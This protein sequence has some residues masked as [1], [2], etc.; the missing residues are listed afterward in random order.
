MRHFFKYVAV[1]VTLLW[2]LGALGPFAAT[3]NATL[4]DVTVSKVDALV[5][6]ELQRTGVESASIALVVDGRLAYAKAFGLARLEPVLAADP[7]QRYRIGSITKQFVAAAMVRLQTQGLLNLD[8][9]LER[10][11]PEAGAAGRASLRQLLS[12][13]AGVREYFPQ[14]YVFAELLV[15]TTVHQLVE[16]IA[17]HPLD[18]SPGQRWKYSNSG[19]VLAGAVV[20]KVTGKSLFQ[21]LREQFFEPMSMTSAVDA[22][23]VGLT[24]QDPIGYSVTGLGLPKPTQNMAAGWLSAAGGLGMSAEDLAKW[25]MALM[26]GKL[27]STQEHKILGTEMLLNNGVGSRYALGLNVRMVGGRRMWMHDG[28][29]PGFIANNI[30][31]PDDGLAIVV[32]TNGDF[33]DVAGSI[34]GRLHRIPVRERGD[35]VPGRHPSTRDHGIRPQVNPSRSAAGIQT[36]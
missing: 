4:D 34:A 5:L 18:F 33:M 36:R 15:P 9:P 32:L 27:L 35:G 29:V 31:F 26:G 19:Y 22:D 20:E 10:H 30:V 14:D 24:T 28:G 25:D 12:H 6:S 21:F 23:G 7:K 16:H 13:T 3:A 17:S 11:L 1:R 2:G 8:D